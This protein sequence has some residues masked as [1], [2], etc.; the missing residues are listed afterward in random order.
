MSKLTTLRDYQSKSIN[1]I[2]MAVIVSQLPDAES[3]RYIQSLTPL[4]RDYQTVRQ[5]EN[6]IDNRLEQSLLNYNANNELKEAMKK[7][8]SFCVEEAAPA[9]IIKNGDT[10]INVE[11]NEEIDMTTQELK[12]VEPFSDY[13][14]ENEFR[15]LEQDGKIVLDVDSTEPWEKYI[16]KIQ[17]KLF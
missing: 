9:I 12:M 3:E 14:S 10:Y 2:F 16:H 11:D 8:I 6:L 13:Y 1:D 4:D 5:L 15:F 7:A 17:E